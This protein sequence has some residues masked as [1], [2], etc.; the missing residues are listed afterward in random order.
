[1]RDRDSQ[2][3]P[4][5]PRADSE[6]NR[7]RII[8]AA[9]LRFSTGGAGTALEQIAR[10]AG[11]GIGTLYRHFP[12]RDALIDAVYRK[13]VDTL[14]D[15]ATALT[16]SLPPEEALR[17]WLELFVDFLDTKQRIAEL[18]NTLVGGAEPLY[19][20]TPARLLPPISMLVQAANDGG[21]MR[22]NLEPLDLLRAIVG[23]A[24]TRPGPNWK[25]QS[26]GLVDLVLRGARVVH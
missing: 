1:M 13:E 4:R 20:S 11:L 17:T 25:E 19:A 23:I 7:A 15:A 6:Q 14:V 10:D 5:K 22:L 26:M 16:N 9:R 21:D 18:L 8:E 24:T 2:R 12:T 3:R